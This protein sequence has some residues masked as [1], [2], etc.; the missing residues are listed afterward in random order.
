MNIALPKREHPVV[1]LQR[2]GHCNDEG[3]RGKEETKV[4][5]HAAHVHM[6]SPNHE[7]QCTDNDDCP[8]HH[9]VAKIFFLAW[10]LMRSDTMPK[11]GSAT[12]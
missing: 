7:A 4:G 2:C 5:V 1:D 10:M 11:A 3:G 9:S 6:V 12:M 8:H